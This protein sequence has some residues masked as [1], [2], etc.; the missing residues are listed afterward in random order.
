[1]LSAMPC[2]LPPSL[3]ADAELSHTVTSTL[4]GLASLL[5]S[6]TNYKVGERGICSA[7]LIAD[8][9]VCDFM[10]QRVLSLTLAIFF[11]TQI[12][13][14]AATSVAS[15]PSFEHFFSCFPAVKAALSECLSRLDSEPFS[16]FPEFRYKD[17]LRQ[18]LLS[19]LARMNE[20]A[21]SLDS[22]GS[23]NLPDI[24]IRT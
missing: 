18:R 19:S 9:C 4:L 21:G 20:L 5:S 11:L 24:D 23:S 13:I 22:A 12:R 3:Q 1:M 17:I 15:P 8:I 6:S 14:N 10:S 7:L 2:P 16:S